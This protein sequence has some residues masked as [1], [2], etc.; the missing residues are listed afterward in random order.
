MLLVKA[1][2]RHRTYTNTFFNFNI[3]FNPKLRCGF[4]ICNSQV[5]L[6]IERCWV[7]RKKAQGMRR[8][9]TAVRKLP[10]DHREA[11]LSS[12][13]RL[14]DTS[15][16]CAFCRETR[17]FAGLVAVSKWSHFTVTI[18]HLRNFSAHGCRLLFC[19]ELG[20]TSFAF[21]FAAHAFTRGDSNQTVLFLRLNY[22]KQRISISVAS[23]PKAVT[24]SLPTSPS[25]SNPGGLPW[26]PIAFSS[27]VFFDERFLHV[28]HSM[29]LH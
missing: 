9:E 1:T 4:G 11:Q 15:C 28:E 25:T 8:R 16:N 2:H 13:K 10:S 5:L 27:V 21:R 29:S 22:C 7:R 6:Y 3:T 26:Q 23:L 20:W 18:K 19:S 17:R 24:T 14:E 12:Q